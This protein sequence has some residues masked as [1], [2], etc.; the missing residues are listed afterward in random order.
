MV[1]RYFKPSDTNRL[2]EIL[3]LNGQYDFP[4]VEGPDAMNRFFQSESSIFL[5][6][7][8]DGNVHGMIRA[9]YDGSRA[10]IHLLSVEPSVQKSGIGTQLVREAEKLLRAMGAPGAAV[11]VGDRSS[12]FW[13]QLGYHKL[14]VH[15][16]LKEKWS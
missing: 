15:L 6:A 7:E 8:K 1:I 11:T 12:E 10:F 3:K 16:H 13:E 14:P 5:V 9:V 4:D 2:V